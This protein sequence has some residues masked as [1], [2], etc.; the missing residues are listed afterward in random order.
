M[1]SLV[2]VFLLSATLGCGEGGQVQPETADALRVRA[3]QGDADAQYNLGVMYDQG[4][5]VAQDDAEAMRWW[6]LAAEQGLADAQYNLGVS[7]VT[8]EGVPQDYV[9]AHLWYNLAA[10]RSTGDILERSV[11]GRDVAAATA[12]P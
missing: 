1:K 2:A 5:G 12:D 11:K 4:R 9:Q 10:S 8:G 7:Y 3:E 6:R